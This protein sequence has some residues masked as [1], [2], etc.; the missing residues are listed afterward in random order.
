MELE[1]S[2]SYSKQFATGPYPKPYESNARLHTL[3]LYHPVKYYPPI[4][5]YV[6]K[7]VSSLDF[8]QKCCMH[9]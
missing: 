9:F 2:L 3:S 7:A 4:Y 1:G 5:A 8:R 6:Y